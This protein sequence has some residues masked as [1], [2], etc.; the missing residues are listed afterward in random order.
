MSRHLDFEGIENF[1]DF[2]GYATVSGRPMKCGAFFRSGGH[3][4]AT[5][6]DLRRLSELGL[7]AVIDLRRAEER[8]RDPSRRWPG[9]LAAVV[10]ND[11]DALGVDAVLRERV[12]ERLLS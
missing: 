3:A 11:I 10:E 2:G 12:G 8:R 1:R 7:A 4:G 5:D 6:A 9:F